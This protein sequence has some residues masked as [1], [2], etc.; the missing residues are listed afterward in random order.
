MRKGMLKSLSVI[1]ALIFVM[2]L[3]S[4]GDFIDSVVSR[5]EEL[6]TAETVQ[7]E[8]E[9]DKETE[10][11]ENVIPFSYAPELVP[12]TLPSE[13][14]SDPIEEEASKIIDGAIC[15]AISC[16]NAMKD[17]RH[18][19]KTSAYEEDPNGF[20]S[21][22]DAVTRNA[23]SSV[24]SKAEKLETFTIRKEDFQGDLKKGFFSLNEPMQF[25]NPFV[26]SFAM[27]NSE[28]RGET[29]PKTGDIVSVYKSLSLDYFDPYK[30]QNASVS[31]EKADIKKIEHDVSLFEH[32]IKRIVRFMPKNM[33][34]YDKYYYLS[35]VVTEQASY[36]QRPDNCYT[37]FGALVTGRAVCEGYSTA[38]ALLCK[39][40]DLYCAYRMSRTHVWNMV[41]LEDGIYNVD[42]TWADEY[43][44]NTYNWYRYFVRTD[45]QSSDT[46][47]EP[48]RGVA[49]TGTGSVNT[50]T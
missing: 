36:D 25:C 40:A 3:T 27:L 6:E 4:C 5:L 42:L 46:G 47:H 10:K 43:E 41:K 44:Q 26:N 22:L 23:Y 39:E 45:I 35:V 49:G 12:Y 29:D 28:T 24:C 17:D 15:K 11:Q 31:Q 9:T 21:S 2:L 30:D 20:L 1:F 19:S 14:F 16:I 32:I 38:F 18:S 8:K 37:A 50:Y 13:T 34:A 7:T 33:S 48:V